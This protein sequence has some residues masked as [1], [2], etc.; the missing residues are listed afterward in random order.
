MPKKTPRLSAGRNMAM[1]IPAHEYSRT[2]EFYRDVLRLP[3]IE[4]AKP[5][6]VFAF[7]DKRLWL[8][9]VD[10]LSQAEIWLE[11]ETDDVKEAEAYFRSKGVAQRDE[12]EALPKNFKGFWISSPANIIHLVS[13]E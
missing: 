12:I 7:G 1:K 5:N 2:V 10:H 6:V 3:Q 8:D 9:K 13:E 11:I 4:E